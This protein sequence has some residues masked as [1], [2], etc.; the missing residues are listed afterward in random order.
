MFATYPWNLCVGQTHRGCECFALFALFQL[1]CAADPL[2]GG[3]HPQCDEQPGIGGV[4]ADMP[5]DGLDV[6]EPGVQVEAADQRQTARAGESGSSRWSSEV[7]LYSHLIA[8]RYAEPGR[9]PTGRL[10]GLLG[11]GLREF[12]GQ[13]GEGAH[14]NLAFMRAYTMRQSVDV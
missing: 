9:P 6:G 13:E 1:A 12:A 3:E 14:G 7:Q 10:G 2:E 8:V 11:R 4:A 5:L